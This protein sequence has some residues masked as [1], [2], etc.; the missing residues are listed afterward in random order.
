MCSDR[1]YEARTELRGLANSGEPELDAVRVA[2]VRLLLVDAESVDALEAADARSAELGEVALLAFGEADAPA[3]ERA[4]G[5]FVPWGNV[6]LVL[7]LSGEPGQRALLL[8]ELLESTGC[9]AAFAP[10]ELAGDLS[11]SAIL[12]PWALWH[13]SLRNPG[14]D[15]L[16]ASA[17]AGVS[18]R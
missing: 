18:A 10:A 9:G 16:A 5:E 4:T 13:A 1:W 14:L 12:G 15:A 3:V 7:E 11:P 6:A 8:R 2:V 17:G